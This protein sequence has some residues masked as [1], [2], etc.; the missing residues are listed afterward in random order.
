MRIDKVISPDTINLT[1]TAT[2]KRAAL[3]EMIDMLF[4]AG[5]ITDK[6][7]FADEIEK[8]E[9][10]ETTDLGFGV[11]IP[12]GIS[13]AVKQASIAIGKL[14]TPIEWQENSE[15]KNPP[16]YAIFLMAS[17]PDKQGREHI[18]IISKVA[19]LLIEDDFVEFLQRNTDEAL[20][21]NRIR[22]MIGDN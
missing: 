14:A 11:A 13:D 3:N 18:E 20:L 17:S 4:K 19:S 16:I 21:I 2:T 12:H 10:T 9:S 15:E 6:K 22:T 8:R 7:R 1:M 5:R